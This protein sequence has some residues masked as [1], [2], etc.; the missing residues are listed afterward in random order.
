VHFLVSLH[1]ISAVLGVFDFVTRR[2][3]LLSVR[4]EDI[5]H[6]FFVSY[7]ARP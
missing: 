2:D 6:R 4:T 1:E 5:E 3:D 7:S